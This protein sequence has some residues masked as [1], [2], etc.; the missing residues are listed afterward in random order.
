MTIRFLLGAGRMVLRQ[1]CPGTKE[2][3][4]GDSDYSTLGVTP[5]NRPSGNGRG[6]GR[7]TAEGIHQEIFPA[8]W[9]PWRFARGGREFPSPNAARG[10]G[11][12]LA[13]RGQIG[14]QRRKLFSRA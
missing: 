5:H 4:E 3:I 2:S 13:R 9:N 6:G 8:A 1:S 7:L 11:D 10:Y 12:G 14:G